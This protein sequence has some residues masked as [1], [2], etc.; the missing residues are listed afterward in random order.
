MVEIFR[1]KLTNMHC[2]NY[3]GKG[4]NFYFIF[5]FV[6]CLQHCI[7]GQS[8]FRWLWRWSVGNTNCQT[9]YGSK[10]N[11]T[12]SGVSVKFVDKNSSPKII[13]LM[14]HTRNVCESIIVGFVYR[15]GIHFSFSFFAGLTDFIVHNVRSQEWLVARHKMKFII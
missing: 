1:T 12:V 13:I 15:N 14:V 6:Q 11:L 8:V 3:I 9:K 7:F 4:P 10:G 5:V 2:A